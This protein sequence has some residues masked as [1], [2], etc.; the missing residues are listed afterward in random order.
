[1]L[2][3]LSDKFSIG[4]VLFDWQRCFRGVVCFRGVSI[5]SLD[6]D[7]TGILGQRDN[8]WDIFIETSFPI[9]VEDKTKQNKPARPFNDIGFTAQALLVDKQFSNGIFLISFGIIL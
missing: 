3:L 9:Q 8:T 4:L 6:L 2:L 7:T 5:Y 1:M